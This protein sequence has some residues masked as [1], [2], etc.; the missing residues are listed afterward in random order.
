MEGPQLPAPCP[1]NAFQF[2]GHTYVLI[3]PKEDAVCTGSCR[4]REGV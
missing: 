1:E 2:R 4:T 3:T